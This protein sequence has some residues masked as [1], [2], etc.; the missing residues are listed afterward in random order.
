MSLNTAETTIQLVQHAL[1][2][3]VTRPKRESG[4]SHLPTAEVKNERSF[5]YTSSSGLAE[6]VLNIYL[7][8]KGEVIPLHAMEA[9]GGRGGSSYSYLT[10]ALDEWS[11]SRPGRALP[12]GKGPPVPIG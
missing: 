11:A 8:K 9:H 7:L 5:I 4:D 3:W 6:Q 1:F 12:P 2:S 10:S